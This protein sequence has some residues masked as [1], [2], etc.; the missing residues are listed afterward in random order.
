MTEAPTQAATAPLSIT[1]MAGPAAWRVRTPDWLARLEQAT[2]WIE[3]PDRI[4]APALLKAGRRRLIFILGS[5]AASASEHDH[6]RGEGPRARAVVKAFPLEGWRQ[7][8]KQAKY[9]PAETRNL[10]L[11]AQRGLPVP[12]V[13]AAGERRRWGMVTWN[14]LVTGFVS[15]RPL[16]ARLESA[17]APT[18]RELLWRVLPL[19][20]QVYETGCNHI[21]LGPHAILLA[22]RAGESD[23][24]IDFQYCVF[25]DRPAPLTFARQA[26][27]FGWCLTAHWNLVGPALLH[28]WS[29][30]LWA[31]AG[32]PEQALE[33]RKVYQH[34]LHHRAS[35]QE[36]LLG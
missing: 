26:G 14:A 33:L 28:E 29:E 23:H 34:H 24:L 31:A 21:D 8:W 5:D 6:A 25:L 16:R 13:F 9:A 4:P 20:R 17:D 1:G 36:R 18:Q 11:A 35:I 32:L 12:E 2:D 15:G 19:F 3:H 27:Y 30:A 22:D 10:L 7:R